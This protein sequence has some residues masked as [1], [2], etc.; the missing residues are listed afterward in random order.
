MAAAQ[1]PLSFASAPPDIPQGVQDPQIAGHRAEKRM[2]PNYT[3]YA[4]KMDELR[5]LRAAGRPLRAEL[6]E[7]LAFVR[8]CERRWDVVPGFWKISDSIDDRSESE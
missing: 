3:L 5:A 7:L 4:T 8:T 1:P 2:G 6:D